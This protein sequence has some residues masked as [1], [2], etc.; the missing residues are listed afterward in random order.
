MQRAARGA[1]RDMLARPLL[2]ALPTTPAATLTAKARALRRTLLTISAPLLLAL[3]AGY[4][5]P[6][7]L[8]ELSWRVAATLVAVAI[9]ASTATYVAFLTVGLG[10]TRPRGGAFGSL[11]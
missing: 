1:N 7:W 5:H 8:P 3:G 6:Q 10:S 2:G 11:E 4:W 9:Y